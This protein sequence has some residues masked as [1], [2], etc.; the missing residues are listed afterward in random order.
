MTS[1]SMAAIASSSPPSSLPQSS[2]RGGAEI[3]ERRPW[4]QQQR[5]GTDQP[6]QIRQRQHRDHEQRIERV[7]RHQRAPAAR[8]GNRKS[9]HDQQQQRRRRNRQQQKPGLDRPGEPR[10]APAL[11]D[12]LPGMQKQ[13]RPQRTRQH[14]RAEL[15]AGR[16]EGGHRHGQ[17]HRKHGL[18]AADDAPRQQIERPEGRDTADLAPADRRRT[19][20]CRRRGRRCRRARARAAGPCRCRPDIPG[21]RRARWRGRRAG[22]GRAASPRRA[23]ARPAAA[24]QATPPAAAGRGSIRRSGR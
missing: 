17:Q 19:R 3:A 1:T 22:C 14:Q 5:I 21:R 20:G 18:L 15:E 23:T 16:A 6:D 2:A 11:A 9:R 4:R 7:E 10:I 24:R 13:Q 12:Q 8:G